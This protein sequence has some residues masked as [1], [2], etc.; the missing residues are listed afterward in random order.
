ME[1]GKLT[2]ITKR[3][4]S[5]EIKTKYLP[6]YF[7]A[8]KAAV[9]STLKWEQACHITGFL[10]KFQK[11]QILFTKSLKKPNGNPVCSKTTFQFSG[12]INDTVKH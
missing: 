11:G 8:K 4:F 7:Q 12:E 2:N 6:T 1:N 10:A 5:T 9:S 3:S